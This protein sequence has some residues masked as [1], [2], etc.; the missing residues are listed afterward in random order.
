M[1]GRMTSGGSVCI[2]LVD[3]GR[4]KNILSQNWRLSVLKSEGQWRLRQS[5]GDCNCAGTTTSDVL[6]MVVQGAVRSSVGSVDSVTPATLQKEQ[7][8]GSFEP[9]TH[10]KQQ[11]E[12]SHSFKACGQGLVTARQKYVCVARRLH[13]ARRQSQSA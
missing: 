1:V 2:S 8:A 4:L 6:E 12:L 7:Q 10:T 9:L 5:R 13:S 11:K 3:V